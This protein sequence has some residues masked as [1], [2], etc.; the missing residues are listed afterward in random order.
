M[1]ILVLFVIKIAIKWNLIA[2]MHY[3]NKMFYA[4]I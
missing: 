3:V 1:L 4:I 2:I